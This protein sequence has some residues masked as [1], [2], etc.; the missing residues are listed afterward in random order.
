MSISDRSRELPRVKTPE[1]VHRRAALVVV[2]AHGLPYYAIGHIPGAVNIP[3]HHV[4]RLAPLRVGSED[5]PVVV[6]GGSGSSNAIIVADQLV[7]L[8]YQD[9]AVYE[10]G[11]EGWIAAGLPIATEEANDQR[12]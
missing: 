1:L 5:V 8:G 7:R 11:L 6:Y 12:H 4:A 10:D 2:D 9:V 3:P